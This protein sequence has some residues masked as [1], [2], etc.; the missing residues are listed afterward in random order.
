MSLHYVSIYRPDLL[1][2][3]Q[4]QVYKGRLNFGNV[5]RRSSG[6]GPWKVSYRSG[7]AEIQERASE[8][9]RERS[10][11]FSILA[12]ISKESSTNAYNSVR[13]LLSSIGF[14]VLARPNSGSG[15][16]RKHR[17]L[18]AICCQTLIHAILREGLVIPRMYMQSH[19]KHRVW[20]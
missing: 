19:L 18:L 12:G 1:Y 4:I 9:A 2:R 8:P 6:R 20:K 17:T 3:I 5:S 14:F 16:P 15:P 13:L 10:C 11:P 7:F